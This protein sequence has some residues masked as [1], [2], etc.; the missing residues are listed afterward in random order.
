MASDA[1]VYVST[2][3]PFSTDRAEIPVLYKDINGD[4]SEYAIA[5]YESNPNAGGGGGGSS[6]PVLGT[7]HTD[8]I[9][10]TSTPT[11]LAEENL[12]R[13]SLLII[14]N[15]DTDTLYL[16]V[17]GGATAD[18]S[19]VAIKPGQNYSTSSTG[20]MVEGVAASGKTINVTVEETASSWPSGGGM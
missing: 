13:L 17:G 1:L 9:Q 15:S 3:I 2:P 18:Y 4:G 6:A 16:K 7:A 8:G 20:E 19:S 5:S 14:N 10:V 11:T 12:N